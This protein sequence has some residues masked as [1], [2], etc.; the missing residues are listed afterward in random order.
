MPAEGRPAEEPIRVLP[1]LVVCLGG[2]VGSGL[3]YLVGVAA[4]RWLGAEF[5]YGTL[6]VNLAGAFAIGLIQEFAAQ[7]LRVPEPLR[8]FLTAGVLGGL[9][10]YSSFTF[11]TVRLAEAG[12]WWAAVLNVAVTTVACL[13]LCV[14]GLGAAR[15]LLGGRG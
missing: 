10:T 14:L 8:L 5:P 9:T 12:G 13:A 1:V 2:A 7:T 6:I 11:E 15:L 3:R 4:M